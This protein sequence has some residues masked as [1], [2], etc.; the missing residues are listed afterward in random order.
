M[1][2]I[3]KLKIIVIYN[4]NAVGCILQRDVFR[5]KHDREAGMF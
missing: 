1:C 3:H 2:E 4:A 5:L